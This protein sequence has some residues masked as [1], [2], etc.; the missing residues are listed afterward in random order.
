MTNPS[1]ESLLREQ[2]K[3]ET[4]TN[5]ENSQ[6]E[7]DIDYV[8]WLEK[9]ISPSAIQGTDNK[10]VEEVKRYDVYG[11]G[12]KSS[13]YSQESKNGEWIYF[14]DFERTTS[15]FQ[16]K[17]QEVEELKKAE[18]KYELAFEWKKGYDA[19]FDA[20]EKQMDEELAG[21]EAEIEE[22]KTEIISLCGALAEYK[23][24]LTE[25]DREIDFLNDKYKS[26][27]AVKEQALQS[28]PLTDLTELR[29]KFESFMRD[30]EMPYTNGSDVAIWN[31]FEKHL[32]SPSQSKADIP[33]LFKEVLELVYSAHIKNNVFEEK[34]KQL[35]ES[36]LSP[37][38]EIG[39]P[40][41]GEAEAVEFAEWLNRNKWNS[42][43][44]TDLWWSVHTRHTPKT[45]E[46]LYQE[47]KQSKQK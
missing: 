42:S 11:T 31:F 8:Q 43:E 4:G 24:E 30:K 34:L 27:E 22:K 2:F 45:T 35:L 44:S 14:K 3:K 38:R 47:F 16:V 5:F 28:T 39:S 20:I 33:T 15:Q 32:H 21:K 19:A 41:T 9:K 10:S 1:K 25:K 23:T 12:I 37:Q 18:R 17:P 7:P 36:K 29:N 46:Q 40:I 26:L 13:V 6:G